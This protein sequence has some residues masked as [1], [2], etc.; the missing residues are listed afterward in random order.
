MAEGL[1]EEAAPRLLVQRVHRIFAPAANL[2]DDDTPFLLE[3]L[4]GHGA[5]EELVGQQVER[6][7]DVLVEDLEVE[8]HVVV[9]GV[10][11]VLAAEL[12]GPPVDGELVETARALEQHVL[13]HVGQA[14]MPAVV[15]GAHRDDDADGR[16][17]PRHGGVQHGQIAMPEAGRLPERGWGHHPNMSGSTRSIKRA[18]LAEYGNQAP[19][20]LLF[21]GST[22][23]AC[24]TQNCRS[25][26]A[27]PWRVPSP[28]CLTPP[29]GRPGTPAETTH[30]F[31]HTLPLSIRS[32]S[33][34]PRAMSRGQTR[35]LRPYS[36]SLASVS[37]S[38]ALPT[39]IT[40]TTGPND[41][42]R[43]MRMP[44]VTPV[45]TVGSRKSPVS[46]PQRRPPHSTRAPL[47][48]ASA[49]CASTIAICRGLVKAP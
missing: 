35:A 38:S 5:R 17:R 7:V 9:A 3:A 6:V 8:R 48:T 45:S 47:A 30:S 39:G 46:G 12:A 40:G 2:V 15:A 36:E 23:M 24:R 25:P 32:A 13:R 28:L 31:T 41:S 33:A 44:C 18:R 26:S 1:A 49:R 20:V 42:S 27:P 16:E 29:K 34:M 37:A 10:G 21:P 11:V 14:R 19:S 43:M 22:S 4:V